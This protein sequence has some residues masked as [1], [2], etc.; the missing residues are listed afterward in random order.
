[1]DWPEGIEARPIVLDD[2]IALAELRAATEKVDDEGEHEDADDVL[3]W[4]RHPWFDGPRGSL[5]LWSGDRMAG[6][7]VIWS[8]P[9]PRDADQINFVGG[10]HPDWRR[11]G[12]GGRL[13]DWALDRA[14]E[15]HRDRHP[16]LAGELHAH[17]GDANTGLH[18]MLE[19]AGFA[20]V[21]YFVEMSL[22]LTGRP[23]AG[24]AVPDGL[25]LTAFED[26][27]DEATRLAHNEAFLDHW[28]STPREPDAWRAR[29]TASKSFRPGQ[30]HLLLDGEDVASYVLSYEYDADTAITGRRDLY[31][32]QVGTR[33]PY[34]GRGAANALLAST[35]AAAEAAGFET[36]SLGVDAANPT[37]ALGLYER[38]GFTVA[39]R[40]TTYSLPLP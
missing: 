8:G 24:A 4:L 20:Q 27:Y 25:M 9:V 34:R 26:R 38:L 2:A 19:G 11:Q 40:S 29:T 1:M 18:A 35:L 31:I 17:S 36:A 30:S 21:R 14:G 3:E 32:G 37:G 12:L 33:R 15:R 16:D 28:G 5:G 7:A 23:D 22:T 39:R 13:L 6:W 10:V